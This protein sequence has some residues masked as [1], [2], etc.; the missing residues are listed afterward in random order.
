MAVYGNERGYSTCTTKHGTRICV[1][2]IPRPYNDPD[3]FVKLEGSYGRDLRFGYWR[4][5]II[6]GCDPESLR[7][8][9]DD[10]AA[11]RNRVYRHGTA[12]SEDPATFGWLGEGYTKDK[13]AVYCHGFTGR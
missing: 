11:D 10:Y 4:E 8:L 13:D 7:H 5:H 3:S 6:D 1:V 9:V 2:G 12:G